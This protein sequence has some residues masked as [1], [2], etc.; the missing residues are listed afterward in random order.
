MSRGTVAVINKAALRHN[1]DVVRRFA[2]DSKVWAIVKAN[3]YGHGATDVALALTGADGFAVATLKE[4][5]ELRDSGVTA[6]IL[7]LE[8]VAETAQ[9]TVAEQY[10]LQVVLQTK[11]QVM[12]AI[13]F[14][15]SLHVWVKIDTGMHRLGLLPE[16]VAEV[17]ALVSGASRIRVAGWMTHFACADNGPGNSATV[18]QIERFDRV[19]AATEPSCLAN[20]AAIID[21]PATQ[22]DWVRPGIMLY[23]ASPFSDR[24]A[25]SLGLLP[26]MSLQA[27]VISLRQIDAG[28]FVGYGYRWQAQ[29][30]TTIA[31]LAIGY[32]DG[33]PRHAPDGTPVWLNGQIV[34]LVGRVSMDMVM[35]DVTDNAVQLGDIAQLWGDQLPVDEVASH[36]D[37]IGYELLTRVSPRVE[38]SYLD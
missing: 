6:P 24:S 5:V 30:P 33:Y 35:V 11:E 20:S 26:A 7:L 1:L 18:H 38:R 36:I 19:V 3:A 28:E 31:T 25:E 10:G 21:W 37:T 29:R 13:E 32:G 34:P 9:L 2:P 27:P 12:D 23:G 17:R 14:P 4:A 8:G 22:R 15:G 16:Q